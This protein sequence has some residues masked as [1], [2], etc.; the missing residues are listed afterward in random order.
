MLKSVW[1]LRLTS[2]DTAG[3]SDEASLVAWMKGVLPVMCCWGFSGVV[4][5]AY[6][7]NPLQMLSGAAAVPVPSIFTI[8]GKMFGFNFTATDKAERESVLVSAKV[9]DATAT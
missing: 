5:L 8:S 2:K 3:S 1:P 6:N 7:Y 4:L 9:T